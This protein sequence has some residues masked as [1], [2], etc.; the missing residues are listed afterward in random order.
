MDVDSDSEAQE[1]DE[2]AGTD[3]TI[4]LIDYI[5]LQS[6]LAG[7]PSHPSTYTDS[8]TPDAKHYLLINGSSISVT[9][10]LVTANLVCIYK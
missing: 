3:Q 1:D 7:K 6:Q 8:E 10:S 4:P 2:M 5:L 9:T